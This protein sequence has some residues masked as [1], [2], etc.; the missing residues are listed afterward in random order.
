MVGMRGGAT[1]AH[2]VPDRDEIPSQNIDSIRF[3]VDPIMLFIY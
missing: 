2:P 1:A 3:I